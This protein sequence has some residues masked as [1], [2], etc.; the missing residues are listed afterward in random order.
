MIIPRSSLLLQM[1]LFHSFLM[2]EEYS[3][4]IYMYHIFFIHSSVNGHLDCLQVL[5]FVNSA[6]ILF[7]M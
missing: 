3:I 1:A 7:T 2:F 4:C 5:A 6:S